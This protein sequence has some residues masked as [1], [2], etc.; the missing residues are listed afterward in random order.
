MVYAVNGE[1]G[2]TPTCI[3][4]PK[5]RGVDF[6]FCL[7]QGRTVPNRTRD[8]CRYYLLYKWTIEG[9]KNSQKVIA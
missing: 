3:D 6:V 4:C 2:V 1:S 9:Y 7:Q 8:D 5:R